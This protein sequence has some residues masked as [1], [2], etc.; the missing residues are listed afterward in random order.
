MLRVST[1]TSYY[2]YEMFMY[3][4]HDHYVCKNDNIKA[5]TEPASISLHRALSYL[6]GCLQ[7]L[8]WT[9]GLPLKLKA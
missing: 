4:A 8:D 6:Y 2:V 7:S 3:I 9:T 5:L 1:N